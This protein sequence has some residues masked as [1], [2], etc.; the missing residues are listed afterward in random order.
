MA[1]LHKLPPNRVYFSVLTFP[2]VLLLAMVRENANLPGWPWPTIAAAQG[3]TAA[4]A[5][6]VLAAVG[7]VLGLSRQ[8]RVSRKMQLARGDVH[9]LFAKLEA[10]DD[11]LHVIWAPGFPY[12]AISPF[13]SLQ[14]FSKR[15]QLVLGWPQ[16]T[17]FSDAMLRKFDIADLPVALYARPDIVMVGRR[18]IHPFYSRYVEEHHGA[19]VRFVAEHAGFSDY[20]LAGHFERIGSSDLPRKADRSA[21][22]QRRSPALFSPR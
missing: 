4:S 18:N 15:H 7:V 10:R 5:L 2:L 17:P 8:Y 20:H 3:R 21:H 6:I 14:W 11:R 12:Q 16:R 19:K 13:D 1:A 9:Q 22:A